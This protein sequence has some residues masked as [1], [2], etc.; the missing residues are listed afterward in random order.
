MTTDQVDQE[1]RGGGADGGLGRD[2]ATDSAPS[3]AIE[4][5]E[6][7]RTSLLPALQSNHIDKGKCDELTRSFTIIF[8][9]K[10][11]GG[12]RCLIHHAIKRYVWENKQRGEPKRSEDEISQVKA[13]GEAKGR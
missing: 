9:V 1:L 4:L 13:T 8:E 12:E 5:L 3:D 10:P 6:S 2:S 11:G 7:N